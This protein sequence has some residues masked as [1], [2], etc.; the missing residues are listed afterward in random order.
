VKGWTVSHL[1]PLMASMTCIIHAWH[2]ERI[3]IILMVRF[4]LPARDVTFLLAKKQSLFDDYIK[5]D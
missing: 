1:L 2:A 4:I 5:K 3:L